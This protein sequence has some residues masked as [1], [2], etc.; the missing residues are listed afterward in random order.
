MATVVGKK[1][2]RPAPSLAGPKAKKFHAEKPSSDVKGK[3]RSQPVTAPLTH[4]EDGASS[5]GEDEQEG[6]EEVGDA[7]EEVE[8]GN[9]LNTPKDPNGALCAFSTCIQNT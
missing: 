2:K 6:Y 8:A 5:A 3:K 7:G 4:D 9:A 1:G